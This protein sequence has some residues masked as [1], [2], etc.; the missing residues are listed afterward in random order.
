MNEEITVTSTVEEIEER[1]VI[2]N[3]KM[4]ARGAARAKARMV[5]VSVKDD[6]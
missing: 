1:K 4:E 6:V 2:V 3:M 5:A